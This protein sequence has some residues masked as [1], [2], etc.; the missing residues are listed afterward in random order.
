VAINAQYHRL[1]VECVLRGS[2]DR[3]VRPTGRRVQ[4]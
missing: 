3:G 2:V 1:S 4:V